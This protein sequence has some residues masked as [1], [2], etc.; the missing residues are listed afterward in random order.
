MSDVTL[1]NAKRQPFLATVYHDIACRRAK[2]CTCQI[3]YYTGPGGK[4]MSRKNPLS[5]QIDA[6]SSKEVPASVLHLPQVQKAL[7]SKWLVRVE[8]KVQPKP[9]AAAPAAPAQPVIAAA[10]TDGDKPTTRRGRG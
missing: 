5:F 10:P 7:K 8:T 2:S 9:V 4:R 3:E 1:R 6:L